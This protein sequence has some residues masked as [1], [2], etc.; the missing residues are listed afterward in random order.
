MVAE[1]DAEAEARNKVNDQNA[2]HLDFE[3]AKNFVEHPHCSHQ[4]KEDEE[5]TECDEY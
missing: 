1:F 5:Y 3:A 2:I 4:L